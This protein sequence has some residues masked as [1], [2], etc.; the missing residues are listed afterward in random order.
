MK[1]TF[2]MPCYM[3]VP[4][5]GFR[6]V[7]EYANRL[8]ARGHQV[9]VV[10]P[11]A[12]KFPPPP[13]RKTLRGRVRLARLWIR[14]RVS[15]PTVDWHPIDSRVKMTFVPDSGANHIPDADVIFATG[16][17]T[18]ASVLACPASKGEKS[19]LIQGYEA[20]M[21]MGPPEFV[22]ATWRAPLHKVVIA[23]WLM[24][25]GESLGCRDL[26]Y[27][28]NGIDQ[29]YRM[30]RPFNRRPKRVVMMCSFVRFKGSS[31]GI[32]ALEIAKAQLPDLD[33]RL[34]GNS[35]RPPWVPPWM[36]YTE[37]PPQ[38]ELI[39]D[40]YNTCSV[41]LGPSLTEGFPLPPAEAAACGCAIVATDIGGHTE[42]LEHGVT[43]LLSPPRNPEALAKNLCTLLT[44]DEF[45]IRLATAAHKNIS[46]FTWER[47]ADLFET[48]L[49]RT[50]FGKAPLSDV[51]ATMLSIDPV[52]DCAISRPQEASVL[53][54][55]AGKS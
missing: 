38:E 27:I 3:W 34:F 19:Y 54:R 20:L 2:L 21:E 48:F 15:H 17:D 24:K 7:Y 32:K 40:I 39:E 51:G 36:S 23:R 30:T 6:V 25:L 4:S 9:T 28:P 55:D 50:K 46:E 31:D 11:R 16:W 26:T 53:L 5:G 22:D 33:V 44:N 18:V 1:V 14:E 43:A 10:H 37:N 41:F 42:Y 52:R 29:R 35:R 12:L 45:R 49:N 47:S 13:S 8:V